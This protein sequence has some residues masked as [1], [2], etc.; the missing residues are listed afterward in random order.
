MRARVVAASIGCMAA[1]FPRVQG[2][3]RGGVHVPDRRRRTALAVL[4]IAA[5]AS[6][7]TLGSR[8]FA[9]G[10][11]PLAAESEAESQRRAA[12]EAATAS[13]RASEGAEDP[14]AEFVRVVAEPSAGRL[15]DTAASHDLVAALAQDS[16]RWN[17]C[18]AVRVLM[19]DG[20]DAAPALEQALRSSDQQLRH[21][22]AFVLRHRDETA[23]PDLFATSVEALGQIAVPGYH[24]TLIHRPAVDAFRWLAT[25]GA[26]PAA[27][28]R[29]GLE[30][31]DA[32]RQFLCA[33]LL[34]RS[35][36]DAPLGILCRVLVEHLNDNRIGGDAL[37]A[38][39]GLYRLGQRALGEIRYARRFADA[40]GL[41]LLELIEL[42]LADDANGRNPS[43]RDRRARYQRL[44]LRSVSEAYLD[45]VR[46]FDPFRSSVPNF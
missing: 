44:G 22:A 15:S 33:F 41:A 14:A 9:A 31:A 8:V 27:A 11:V 2:R 26:E 18:K 12:P 42:D 7:A 35:G 30:S 36:A 40:Q 23:S 4:A 46:D 17:A 10:D 21:L 16:I 39:H 32:Q 25:R 6:A 28:L 43:Y 13:D 37:L 38:A 3:A 1:G 5:C 34:A 19:E 45:P 20:D 24:E 29:R